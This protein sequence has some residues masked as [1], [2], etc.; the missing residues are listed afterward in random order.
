MVTA[1]A[2]PP[3]EKEPFARQGG[4]GTQQIA[5]FG[6]I[7]ERSQVLY[8]AARHSCTPTIKNKQGGPAAQAGMSAMPKCNL[9]AM[10]YDLIAV[11][12]L[13]NDLQ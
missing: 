1:K 8:Q 7:S 9:A 4:G 2:R 12:L 3:Q 6:A 11:L 5:P 10:P 13:T